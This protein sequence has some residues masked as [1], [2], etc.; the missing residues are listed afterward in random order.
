MFFNRLSKKTD[1]E[2]MRLLQQG[3]SRALTELYK[4]YSNLMLRYFYRMLWKDEHK[5]QD[6]VQD[7]FMK[8]IEKPGLYNTD[9]KFSTWFYSVA[10]NMCKNEYRK[11]SYRDAFNQHFKPAESE[12]SKIHETM[13]GVQFAKML[14]ESMTL[15]HEDD[16]SLF[17]LRHEVEMTFGEIAIVLNC[18]EGTAKSRWFYLKKQLAEQ[19]HEYQAVLK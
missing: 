11:Q 14:D 13:D 6:F 19:F 10:H 15:W 3:E 16:R 2:L 12:E 17:V 18:P 9:K 4:R 5:S 1:E 8:I 7:L